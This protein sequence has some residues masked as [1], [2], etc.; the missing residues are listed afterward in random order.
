MRSAGGGGGG[1]PTDS[2]RPT[3]CH[4]VRNEIF[5]TIGANFSTLLL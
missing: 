2:H 1:V 5:V 3:V 4:A